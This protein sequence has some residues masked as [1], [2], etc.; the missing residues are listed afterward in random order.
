MA[1]SLVVANRTVVANKVTRSTNH[2]EDPLGF[3]SFLGFDVAI[4]SPMSYGRLTKIKRS[5]CVM[6]EARVWH[7]VS[8]S[9][10]TFH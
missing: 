2:V 6:I 4:L 3:V 10:F 1:T 8:D 7:D 5:P 9:K